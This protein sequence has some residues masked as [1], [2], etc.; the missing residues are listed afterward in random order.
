MP[1][2]EEPKATDKPKKARKKS[3]DANLFVVFD[4]A[5]N[6]FRSFK[7]DTVVRVSFARTVDGKKEVSLFN[8]SDKNDTLKFIELE[9]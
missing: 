6:A 3:E 4:L 5:K 9:I 7:F 1:E 8:F 2:K